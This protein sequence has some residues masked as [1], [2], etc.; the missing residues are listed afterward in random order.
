[1][2]KKRVNVQRYK[3]PLPIH[4]VDR[5]ALPQLIPHNPVSWIYWAWCLYRSSNELE[6]KIPIKATMH[7]GS[8]WP[9]FLVESQEDMMYLWNN[10]FFGTG[11]MSRSEPT[12]KYRMEKKL[13]PATGNEGG[14]ALEKITAVRRAQ[15][16]AFKSERLRLEQVLAEF[17]KHNTSQQLEDEIIEQHREALRQFK[18]KQEQQ[19]LDIEPDASRVTEEEEIYDD[20]GNIKSL[21][22]L[23]LMPV[24]ALFLSFALPV[25]DISPSQILEMISKSSLKEIQKFIRQYVVYHH[26]RSLRWC[27]RSGVKF[28][29]DFLLYKRG[30]PFQHAEFSIM[31]MDTNE[32]HDYTW[33]SSIARVVNGAKKTLVLCYVDDNGLTQ[34][35]L[36][37]LWNSGRLVELLSHYTVSE[38]VYKRWVPGKNRD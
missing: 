11:Q 35:E 34:E 36:L 38:V 23:E 21:E 3:Y 27:V 16:L 2:A 29:C 9:H 22:R 25:L 12:W 33:Y 15:R 17:R 7:D 6:R 4:P 14:M 37:R 1:M 30:P 32:T 20:E 13:E 18:L 31:A 24:E 8:G 26:Y 10:G 19:L 5:N 28:G